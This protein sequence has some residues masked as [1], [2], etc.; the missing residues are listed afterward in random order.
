MIPASHPSSEIDPKI[1]PMAPSAPSVRK[2]SPGPSRSIASRL[3]EYV[4]GTADAGHMGTAN[5]RRESPPP[6]AAS[7]EG[8]LHDPTASEPERLRR[9]G[10]FG[11][12][13]RGKA[14]S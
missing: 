13:R 3:V 6:A 5:G 8:V 4:G 11:T 9:G 10:A 12:S 2:A 7:G 1:E 14:A